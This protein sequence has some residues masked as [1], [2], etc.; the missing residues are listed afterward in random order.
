MSGLAAAGPAAGA[1]PD[2]A[3]AAPVVTGAGVEPVAF[4]DLPGWAADDHGQAWRAWMA[5]CR[6]S[7]GKAAPSRAG[8]PAPAR[9]AALCRAGLRAGVRDAAAARRFFQRHFAA[10]RITPEGGAGFFTGYYEPEVVGSLTRSAR[11]ATPLYGRPAD[12]VTFDQGKAPAGLEGYAA[13]RR[14]AAGGLEPYPDRAAIEDGALDGQGLE[15]AFLADPIDR[16]FMQVQGSGR[17]RLPDGRVLRLAYDGRN[18]QPYTA[19]GRIA[20]DRSGVPR[21]SMTMD[22]LRAWLA[23]DAGRARTV[24]R[25]NRSFV[26]FRIATELDPALGPIGGEGVPLTP[27]RS[28]AVD[29]AVWPYGLPVYVDAELPGAGGAVEPF[30]H[31][32]IAQDTGSAIVGPAR[33]DIFFGPGEAAG[34]RAGLTRH[35]GSFVVLWPK[36]AAGRR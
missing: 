32:M 28:L 1:A 13:A 2:V 10:F 19:I 20:A 21:S 11:F 14:T 31:L 36:A 17:L 33:G 30:R 25:E 15:R 4:A 9:L 8:R 29:R 35:P 27:L 23:E 34:A 6:A 24:M 22:V 26:F 3:G 7:A 12:L 18:G 5:S 16:F